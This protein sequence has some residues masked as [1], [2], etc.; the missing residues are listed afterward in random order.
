MQLGPR[1]DRISTT[2]VLQTRIFQPHLTKN[3]GIRSKSKC[4]SSTA[5]K[6][7]RKS[8]KKRE[9]QKAKK[10]KSSSSVKSSRIPA[11]GSPCA[12]QAVKSFSRICVPSIDTREHM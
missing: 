12:T 7:A 6:E 1:E 4:S 11:V 9:K 2:L 3:I 8:K 10:S 5:K